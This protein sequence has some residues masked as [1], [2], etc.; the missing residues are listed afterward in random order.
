[1]RQSSVERGVTFEILF[2][3]KQMFNHKHASVLRFH[4]ISN[5]EMELTVLSGVL[6]Q[7]SYRSINLC[8][9]FS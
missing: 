8:C 5:G 4:R 2:H 7:Y 6:I 9:S 3:G 1:M